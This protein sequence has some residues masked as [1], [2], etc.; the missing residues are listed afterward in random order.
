MN[1]MPDVEH[2]LDD[3]LAPDSLRAPDHVLDAVEQRIAG[4][5]RPRMSRPFWRSLVP[6]IAL[7]GAGLAA[8]LVVA[9]VGWRLASPSVGADSTATPAPSVAAVAPT[10]NV[11]TNPPTAA[12][13]SSDIRVY[14]NPR[15]ADGD[16]IRKTELAMQNSAPS[17]C[18]IDSAPKLTLVGSDGTDIAH[19]AGST[20]GSINLAPGLQ[21]YINRFVFQSWCSPNALLP[22]TLE[23]SVNGTPKTV[24]DW[25]IDDPADLPS[26]QADAGTAITITDWKLLR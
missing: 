26:C 15:V 7:Y 24:A 13:T 18:S 3:Y 19:T 12:C 6:R 9:V 22:L 4:Y 17:P 16:T 1:R 20:A 8:A 25:T 11:P 5:P 14:Y 10:T 23:L 21:F 2:V